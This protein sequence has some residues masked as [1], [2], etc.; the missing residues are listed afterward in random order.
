[1]EPL[2]L[3]LKTPCTSIA[4]DQD[5]IFRSL[6]HLFHLFEHFGYSKEKN[7][8]NHEVVSQLAPEQMNMMNIKNEEKAPLHSSTQH[9]IQNSAD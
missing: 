3:N 4:L 8:K 5:N 9:S 1:M 7:I 2:V 6:F